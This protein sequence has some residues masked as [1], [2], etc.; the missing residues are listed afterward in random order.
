[1]PRE[2]LVGLGWLSPRLTA[3]GVRSRFEILALE[4]RPSVRAPLATIGLVVLPNTSG[5]LPCEPLWTGCSPHYWARRVCI[6]LRRT[7]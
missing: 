1:M 5:S 6:Q 7:R 4:G 3:P 2:A